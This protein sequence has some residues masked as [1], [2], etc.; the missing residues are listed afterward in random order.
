MLPSLYNVEQVADLASVKLE[1]WDSFTFE[2]NPKDADT[3]QI[4]GEVDASIP[5]E[6]VAGGSQWH[7]HIGWFEDIEGFQV[8][9]NR[10][11]DVTDRESEAGQVRALAIYT[12]VEIRAGDQS[13]EIADIE[14]HLG[15]LHRRS[16]RLFGETLTKECRRMIGLDLAEYQ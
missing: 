16:L 11:I 12:L 15:T 6:V 1:Y 5:A 4:L 10:N 8:L 7:S 9:I 14:R 3:A 13:L 2:G